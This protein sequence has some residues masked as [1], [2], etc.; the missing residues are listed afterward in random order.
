MKIEDFVLND[1]YHVTIRVNLGISSIDRE[2]TFIGKV[3]SIHSY[4]GVV[5][6]IV[7]APIQVPYPKGHNYYAYVSTVSCKQLSQADI[8]KYIVDL[9]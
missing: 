5:A 4:P 9:L 6:F 2:N 7:L 8:E 3:S 1:I